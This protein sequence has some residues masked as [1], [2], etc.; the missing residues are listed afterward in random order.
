M[1]LT[2]E[3]CYEALRTRDRRFDGRLFVA[4]TSTGIYCRPICP[5][6]TPLFEN[7]EFF[8]HPVLAEVKGY[9]PCLR[10]RPELAP[11]NAPVDRSEKICESLM[12]QID[13]GI[14]RELGVKEVANKLHIS[15]RHLRRLTMDYFGVAPITLAQTQRLLLAKQ[16][17][18]DTTLPIGE[19]ALAS[20]FS[21]LRRFNT[22][23]KERYR[24]TP[25]SIRK[26]SS[27]TDPYLVCRLGYRPPFDW[28][29]ILDFLSKRIITG[30]ERIE[31]GAYLRTVKI[32]KYHGW[33]SVSHR[34]QTCELNINTSIG[35]TPVLGAVL[36][37]IRRLFDL[38]A[39]PELIEERLGDL[40]KNDPGLRVPGAFDGFEMA[41]RA[42][43][44]QQ[45]SV[46]AATTLMSRIVEKWGDTIP[47]E[48]PGRNRLTPTPESIANSSEDEI[49]ALGVVRA[50]ARTI[51]ELSRAVVSGTID[52]DLSVSVPQTLEKLM[53]LPGIGEWTAHYFAM[54]ALRW[55]D[56]FPHSDLGIL[57]A[58]KTEKPKQALKIAE[59]WR[60]WRAYAAM[61]LWKNLTNQNHSPA[62]NTVNRRDTAGA[63]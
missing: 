27:R 1:N 11:G 32:G 45:I 31:N 34:P 39:V 52:L 26:G 4:V 28:Q 21:S 24:L 43:V 50:R 25:S 53:T 44:G 48:Q 15:D 5:T 57:K 54:R 29:G 8:R 10:C 55:P 30:V 9:R 7:C 42:V 22:L 46:K 49:A 58:L 61:H 19:I 18:M 23:F 14:F 36:T 17:L 41:L 3:Q 37:R 33:L 6:K 47:Q 38:D 16:L 35:L 13:L 62:R 12:R 56:A 51:L 2:P 63:R 20:G 40:A 59:H 60:P